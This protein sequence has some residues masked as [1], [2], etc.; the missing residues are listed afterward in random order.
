MK[1][2]FWKSLAVAAVAVSLTACGGSKEGDKAKAE[3][4]GTENTTGDNGGET[5]DL[6]GGENKDDNGTQAK[7]GDNGSGE[8]NGEGNE[9]GENMG[10]PGG[11]GSS[12]SNNSSSNADEDKDDGVYDTED[13][14]ANMKDDVEW[15]KRYNATEDE[16]TSGMGV[17][18][19]KTKD[20][21]WMKF[22]NPKGKDGDTYYIKAKKNTMKEYN[23][24]D[25]SGY[26][27]YL[28]YQG[29]Y[30]KKSNRFFFNAK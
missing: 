17:Y 22:G 19:H 15:V 4:E 20:G 14:E 29:K 30:D 21:Y 6:T 9:N 24:H 27:Y 5:P 28:D 16:S 10:V 25:V 26:G 2:V 11:E 7:P 8:E 1:K 12:D 13:N 23:G 3:G 18:Q